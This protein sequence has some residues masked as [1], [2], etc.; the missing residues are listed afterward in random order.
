MFLI[1]FP[2]IN[3]PNNADMNGSFH[4]TSEHEELLLEPGFDPQFGNSFLFLN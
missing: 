1:F 4:S 3:I 2:V